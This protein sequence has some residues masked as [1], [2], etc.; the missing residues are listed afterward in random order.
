[1]TDVVDPAPDLVDRFLAP[2]GVKPNRP[3]PKPP[4]V[5]VAAAR[6]AYWDADWDAVGDVYTDPLT[7]AG[8]RRQIREMMMT[9]D[10]GIAALAADPEMAA[11]YIGGASPEFL[12]ESGLLASLGRAKTDVVAATLLNLAAR[13]AGD[14]D[15]QYLNRDASRDP[16]LFAMLA[17]EMSAEVWNDSSSAIGAPKRG[18]GPRVCS[19]LWNKGGHDEICALIDMGVDTSLAAQTDARGGLGVYSGFVMPL[20]HVLQKYIPDLEHLGTDAANDWDAA[21]R[22][23]VEGAQKIFAALERNGSA[24]SLTDW[25]EIK[26]SEMLAEFQENPGTIWG[27][28]NMRGPYVRAAHETDEGVRPVRM[29]ELWDAVAPFLNEKAYDK[30]LENPGPEIERIVEQAVDKVGKDIDKV[31][32]NPSGLGKYDDVARDKQ[33]YLDNFRAEATT[34]LEE[35]ASQVPEGTIAR[36]SK[37]MEGVERPGGQI[38]GGALTVADVTGTHFDKFMSSFACKAGLWAA[39]NEGKPVYYCLDGINMDDVINYKQVKNKAI[40]AFLTDGGA[41]DSKASHKEVVTMVEVREI[42]NNWDELKDTVK[43]ANK[44]VMLKDDALDAAILDWK[45]RMDQSDALAGRAPAPAK[46]NFARELAALDPSLPDLL[47]S[48]AERDDDPTE[49]DQDARDIVLKAGYLVKFANTRPQYVVKYLMSKCGVLTQYGLLPIG[50]VGAA[51]T[52]GQLAS[53]DPAASQQQI[54][55]ATVTLTDQLK[56]CAPQFRQPLAQALVNYPIVQRSR[57]LKKLKKLR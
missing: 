2:F 45:T 7:D 47:N 20:Q 5:T 41:T 32:P 14:P 44:G 16:V 1:M 13:T 25:Q 27:F 21:Y 4:N 43:F 23:E 22:S 17:N 51:T 26:D 30:L 10:G 8:A 40:E 34:Y 55:A 49:T 57:K 37:D 19:A 18:L 38:A 33:Q 52:L 9:E 11:L 28:E 50:L 56:H 15:D 24:T 12:A 3:A 46:A 36:S 31:G 39:K 42:L 48:V 6:D 54:D 53:Q 35:F 29:M